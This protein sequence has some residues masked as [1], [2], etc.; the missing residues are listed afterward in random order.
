MN[1]RKIVTP[2][3]SGNPGRSSGKATFRLAKRR[4]RIAEPAEGAR[5]VRSLRK[6]RRSP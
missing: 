6:S 3:V 4:D 5:R 1:E 2:P